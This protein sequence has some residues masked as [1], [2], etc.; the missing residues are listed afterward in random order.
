VR[1]RGCWRGVDGEDGEKC[2]YMDCWMKKIKEDS[3]AKTKYEEVKIYD[4]FQV[5][6]RK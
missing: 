6:A 3:V 1:L 5:T 2:V 4:E